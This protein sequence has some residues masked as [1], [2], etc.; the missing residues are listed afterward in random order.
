MRDFFAI[1]SEKCRRL[2]MSMLGNIEKKNWNHR[3]LKRGAFFERYKR[4]L[5]KAIRKKK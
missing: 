5:N 1:Y 4:V 2:V 3:G